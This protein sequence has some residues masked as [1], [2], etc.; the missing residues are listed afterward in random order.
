MRCLDLSLGLTYAMASSRSVWC[1]RS[2]S[3]IL[4]PLGHLVKACGVVISPC[5]RRSFR[6]MRSRK[7]LGQKFFI[8][9]S[10]NACFSF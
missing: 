2:M 3:D 6:G 7:S 9:L 5:L 8:A 1:A 4:M 10:M